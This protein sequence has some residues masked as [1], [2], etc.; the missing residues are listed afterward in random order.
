MSITRTPANRAIRVALEARDMDRTELAAL[1][2]LH[3]NT[4]HRVVQGRQTLSA[5][6]AA[7]VA[8][9]LGSTPEALG[10]TKAEGGAG[11]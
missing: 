1:A 4:I 7:R 11:L 3:P 6:A 8:S 9:I 2:G 10:L 5:A